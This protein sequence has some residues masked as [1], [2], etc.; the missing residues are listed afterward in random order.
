MNPRIT[1][2][3][4]LIASD[5]G[6]RN[7]FSLVV[8][9][10]LRLAA[11]SLRLARR[12][13]IVSGFFIP[14]AGAGETDGPPG[15][16]VLGDALGRLGID[17]DYLTDR[18]NAPLFAAL[19]VKPQIDTSDYL[20]RVC[21]THLVSVERAGRGRD[22]RYRNMRG[23]DIT[24]TTAPLDELFLQ[25]GR[26]G[27][28][29]IGIGDGGNEIGMGK[30]F[31]DAL[32]AI[33][34]GKDIAS[35]VPTDFCIAAGVSNWGAYGLAG[36]LSVLVGRDLLPSAGECAEG[37]QQ[38]VRDGAAVDGR[39]HRR[40]STVDGLPLSQTLHML[41]SIRGLITPSPLDRG[42]PIVAGILGYGEAG[43]AAA[44]L[45]ARHGHRLRISDERGVTLEPGLV[46]DGVET[47][48]HSI[49][50][51]HDCDLVVASPGV[52]ADSPIIAELHRH[53]VPLMSEM[54]MAY[55]LCD[56]QLVAVTATIGKRTTVELLQRL[57]ERCGRRL[58][59]GGNRGR[60]LSALLT[61]DHVS[62][63]IALAVSSF[64]LETVVHFRPHVAVMLNVNEA[65]LDRH[66]SIGE[67]VRIKSRIF[68]NQ[69]PDDVL[70]LPFDDLRLRSLNRKH[71]GRTFFVSARQTVDRGAWF[72]GDVI[73]VNVEGAV[74]VIEPKAPL[75]E[76]KRYP[77][78]E[79]ILASVV[80]A[81]LYGLDPEGIA[82]ALSDH[83]LPGEPL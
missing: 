53:G 13:A 69:N 37:I 63:P 72:D 4:N 30:V 21:P 70:I 10:Q 38:I 58:S 31:A 47:G 2:M 46:V 76:A 56:R 11:Q 75:G 48:G 39:T 73:L 22:G 80:V 35:T 18:W 29:T 3:E 60:P 25:A 61:D 28:T 40:E 6:G 1:S 41:E 26:R 59:I 23:M 43:R 12:V 5:P 32:A 50:F 33:P 34:N 74:E 8:S 79:N 27:L 14:D 42:R 66:R 36:A 24:A 62:D 52:R 82:A 19:G 81:R 16:K 45:L 71:H 44:T 57:F 83:P 55:Q 9:D 7:V 64:Q 51:L 78:A 49:E 15:A 54:E 17:V 67:Y 20:D 65:H 77:F 68:M